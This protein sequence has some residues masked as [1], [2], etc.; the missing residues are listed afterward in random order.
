[1]V[2][3]REIVNTQ[4]RLRLKL[5]ENLVSAGHR[6]VVLFA[7]GGWLIP[8]IPTESSGICVDSA[9]TYKKEQALSVEVHKPAEPGNTRGSVQLPRSSPGGP[10]PKCSAVESLPLW[11]Q[12]QSPLSLKVGNSNEI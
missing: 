2:A 1:M 5:T 6:A 7:G 4:L 12:T 10:A 8:P 3:C 9:T 11:K